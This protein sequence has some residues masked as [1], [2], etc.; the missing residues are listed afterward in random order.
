MRAGIWSGV[1]AACWVGVAAA[2]ADPLATRKGL[3]LGLQLSSYE[4]EEPDFAKLE[5]ERIGLTAAYTFTG[6]NRLFSRI[7]GRFSYGEL[8]YTGSGTQSGNPDQLFELRALVGRDYRTGGTVW[9]P[10]AGLG[11]RYLYNDGRGV[12]STGYFGYR[13][14]SRYWYVPIGVT[15]RI[16]LGSAWVLAPQLEY[17]A[18]ASGSQT[19]Y[20]T[21]VD[22]AYYYDAHNRQGHGEGA[23]G[24]LALEKGSWAFSAWFNYWHIQDSDVVPVSSTQA[25]L[26]PENY[27][28]EYGVELRYRF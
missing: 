22:P 10:Y 21:D 16:P 1:A 14:E 9:A 12:T 8:D 19:S 27:T 25:G 24:Q 26:E 13:R 20:L 6:D 28:R 11:V 5:G 17:D 15:W 4:Y 7:E 3:E 2:Q 18:F 23:R